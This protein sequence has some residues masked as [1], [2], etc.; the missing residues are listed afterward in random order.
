MLVTPGSE[1]VNTLQ[2]DYNIWKVYRAPVWR[3]IRLV[4]CWTITNRKN[5]S[6]DF[7]IERVLVV[8]FLA[9]LVNDCQFFSKF[10]VV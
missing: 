3:S 1:G 6:P 8:H 5:S 10:Q 7:I 4:L 2:Q 9:T